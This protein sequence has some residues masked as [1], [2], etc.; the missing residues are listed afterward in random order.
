ME[1][2]VDIWGALRSW[3]RWMKQSPH[4]RTNV[5]YHG[6]LELLELSRIMKSISCT[7]NST[8]PIPSLVPRL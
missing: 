5:E 4:R 7:D 8:S 3:R 2:K 6:P 1:F